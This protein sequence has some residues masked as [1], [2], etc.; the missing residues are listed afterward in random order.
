MKTLDSFIEMSGQ[1]FGKKTTTSYICEHRKYKSNKEMTW[2][3]DRHG[4]IVGCIS[5]E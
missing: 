1:S 2:R 5:D 3:I 4:Y